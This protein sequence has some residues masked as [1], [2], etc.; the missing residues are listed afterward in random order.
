MAPTDEE[1]L[2]VLRD[3]DADQSMRAL[4]HAYGGAIYSFA[5]KRLG[6]AG[7]AEEIVQES[8]LRV[9][10]HAD[11]F[12]RRDGSLRNWLYEIAT[13]LVIDAHRRRAA[14]PPLAL[15]PQPDIGDERES[16]EQEVLRWEVRAVIAQ[17]RPEHREVIEL[18]HF[19][20]LKVREAAERLRIPI[21]TVKSRCYYALENLRIA[22][23]EQGIDR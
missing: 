2:D 15:Y 12:N 22:L 1:I 11:R 13:N 21:G 16:L 5:L 17:L 19:D 23:E 20:G 3:G 6:D 4:F 7:L 9:W 18:I 10:Q 8:M 14:R